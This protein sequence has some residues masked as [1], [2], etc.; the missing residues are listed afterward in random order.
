MYIYIENHLLQFSTY[1][2]Y[3]MQTR[4]AL[5]STRWCCRHAWFVGPCPI[6]QLATGHDTQVSL[7]VSL[8]T[9]SFA[10]SDWTPFFYL[11]SALHFPFPY[12]RTSGC[13]RVYLHQFSHRCSMFAPSPS[14]LRCWERVHMNK[15]LTNRS[16]TPYNEKNNDF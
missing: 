6:I 13:V 3:A 8:L 4:C 2:S 11:A 12:G 14:G 7:K 9:S 1:C 16:Q 15:I 5:V 10:E